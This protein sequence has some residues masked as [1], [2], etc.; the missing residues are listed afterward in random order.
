ML[1]L[2]W[3]ETNDG[4]RRS[5]AKP[6]DDPP[7]RRAGE[8]QGY[9]ALRPADLR[10]DRPSLSRSRRT[11]HLALQGQ[12][13]RRDEGQGARAAGG[14]SRLQ[15]ALATA[16]PGVASRA[17]LPDLPDPGRP[18][19]LQSLPRAADAGGSAGGYRGVSR[20][21]VRGRGGTGQVTSA[22]SV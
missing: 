20:A 6:D 15:P 3:K 1:W 19:R 22:A 2:K 16:H 12:G 18:E 9:R 10:H 13:L 7:A 21:A 17:G 8:W 11:G 4:T 5:A 14:I